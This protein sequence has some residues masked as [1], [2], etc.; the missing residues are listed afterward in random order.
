ME[1]K[2]LQ[3][4][5]KNGRKS[6]S[7]QSKIIMEGLNFGW[8]KA[9]KAYHYYLNESDQFSLCVQSSYKKTEFKEIVFL[10]DT[11]ITA[12]MKICPQCQ[13]LR[14]KDIGS[15][16]VQHHKESVGFWDDTRACPNCK[17]MMIF[18]NSGKKDEHHCTSC[19]Q[20]VTV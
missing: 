16:I 5:L 18:W 2:S 12:D 11:E 10:S 3:K 13:A 19:D 17:R 9:I 8:R 15:K 4:T 7:C 14:K 20:M 1:T 6:K